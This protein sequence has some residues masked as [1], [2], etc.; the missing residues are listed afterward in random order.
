[1]RMQLLF[2]ALLAPAS[3][4]PA[5]ATGDWRTGPLAPGTWTYRGLNDGSEAVFT[6]ARVTPRVVVKCSR[7]AR[8]ITLTLA[9]TVPGSAITLATSETQRSLP[10]SFNAQT[11][12]IIAQITGNDAILDAM[13]FSRGRF[14]LS[15]AGGATLVV[16]AWPEVAR[17][18]EDCRI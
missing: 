1:M 11:S 3:L 10:A 14:A 4:L 5:Q 15:V 17:S 6:D 8:V 2:V 7:A 9:S 16:P 13:A 18:I 12:Q